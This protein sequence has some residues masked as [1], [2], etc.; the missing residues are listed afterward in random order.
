MEG[1]VEQVADAVGFARQEL[2]QVAGRNKAFI[3]YA[4]ELQNRLDKI[5]AERGESKEKK[6]SLKLKEEILNSR[7]LLAMKKSESTAL[8]T[9]INN[10]RLSLNLDSR[11][12]SDVLDTILTNHSAIQQSKVIY[13]EYLR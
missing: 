11:L 9:E 6:I 5:K 8:E 2:A 4:S 3:L 12:S 13:F 10:L 7:K 1:K